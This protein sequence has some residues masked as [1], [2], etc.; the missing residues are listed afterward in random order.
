MRG[1]RGAAAAPEAEDDRGPENRMTPERLVDIV[2]KSVPIESTAE[3]EYVMIT[4]KAPIRKGRWRL[5]PP[6]VEQR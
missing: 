1:W 4:R 5:M 6:E 2:E 3:S